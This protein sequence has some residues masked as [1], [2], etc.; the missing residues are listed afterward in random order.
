M[1]WREPVFIAHTKMRPL[2]AYNKIFI[3]DPWFSK[4]KERDGINLVSTLLVA[5]GALRI[6]C[7]ARWHDLAA[8]FKLDP[9]ALF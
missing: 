8:V 3:N 1:F 2:N 5:M 4:E 9:L 6:G 7:M